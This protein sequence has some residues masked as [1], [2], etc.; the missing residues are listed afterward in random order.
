MTTGLVP[1]GVEQFLSLLESELRGHQRDKDRLLTE[2]R[3]G[4]TDATAARVQRGVPLEEAS[5]QS[6]T[7]F[8]SVDEL[9]RACQPELSVRQVRRTA[10]GVVLTVPALIGFWQ[11]LFG[12]S[13][14]QLPRAAVLLA[15]HLAGLGASTAVLGAL[16]LALTGRLS[17]W[18]PTPRRLPV[19]VGL[20]GIVSVASMTVAPLAMA[21]ASPP[22]AALWPSVLLGAVVAAVPLSSV[23][24]S[25]WLCRSCALQDS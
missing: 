9:A 15:E 21:A 24:L 25:A 18:V 13:F 3:S 2:L 4:L 22:A 5:A 10:L 23:A 1:A 16:T 12:A 17:R 14:S 19:V 11:L 20:I 6:L 7:Q 8:G